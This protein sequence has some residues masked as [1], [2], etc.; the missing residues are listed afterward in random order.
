MIPYLAL[1]VACMA[2][3]IAGRATWIASGTRM[4]RALLECQKRMEEL[5]RTVEDLAIEQRRAR[6]REHARQMTKD[7]VAKRA[8][9]QDEA[10][11]PYREPEKWKSWMMRQNTRRPINGSDDE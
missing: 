4:N 6:L 1:F 2:L 11:D 3:V 7:R 10:P 8:K 5:T 9:D